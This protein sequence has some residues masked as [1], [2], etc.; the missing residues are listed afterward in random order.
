MP[1]RSTMRPGTL[2]LVWRSNLHQAT[3]R[4]SRWGLQHAM[5]HAL[6]QLSPCASPRHRHH[7]DGAN[8]PPSVLMQ[9]WLNAKVHRVGSLHPSG[10]ELMKTISGSPLDPQVFL[11]Y[12]RTKYTQLYKLSL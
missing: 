10:D 3:S 8:L 5:N 1:A 12:L 9:A 4:L 2:S 6:R 7:L 11:A